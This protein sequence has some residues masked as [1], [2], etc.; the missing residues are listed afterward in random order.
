MIS[1]DDLCAALDRYTAHHGPVV[2][3]A[4]AAAAPIAAASHAPSPSPAPVAPV[5]PAPVLQRSAPATLADFTADDHTSVSTE[6]PHD[7]DASEVEL[8][9]VLSDEE[10]HH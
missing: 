4:K 3:A 6:L 7:D 10:S 5:A 9:D 1:Y 2:A 8:H